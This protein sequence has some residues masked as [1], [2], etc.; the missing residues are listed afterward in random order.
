MDSEKQ[1]RLK[2]AEWRTGSAEDFLD[3]LAEVVITKYLLL[4]S[5]S[6]FLCFSPASKEYYLWP[7]KNPDL[8]FLSSPQKEQ[9]TIKLYS[10]IIGMFLTPVLS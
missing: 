10:N 6:E 5:K 1:K 8:I 2:S 3:D 7:I 9:E 4:T